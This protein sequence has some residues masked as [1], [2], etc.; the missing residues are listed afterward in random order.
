MMPMESAEEPG[1]GQHRN[2]NEKLFH[3]ISKVAGRRLGPA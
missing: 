1:C 2:G 3:A